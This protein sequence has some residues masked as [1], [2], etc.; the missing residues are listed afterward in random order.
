MNTLNTPSPTAKYT[1][2][3]EG[4]SLSLL[5]HVTHLEVLGD[6]GQLV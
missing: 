1:R 2:A 5:K 4:L 3:E 6:R